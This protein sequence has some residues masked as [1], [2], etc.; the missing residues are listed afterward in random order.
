VPQ[1]EREREEERDRET[2]LIIK[3]SSAAKKNK[4][5]S[6]TCNLLCRF[7]LEKSQDPIS[8]PF[9]TRYQ[10]VNKLFYNHPP[11]FLPALRL[12]DVNIYLINDFSSSISRS[13][14]LGLHI[15]Q[16]KEPLRVFP[17]RITRFWR[18]ISQLSFNYQRHMI[19]QMLK[20][21]AVN[22]W[23]TLLSLSMCNLILI[24]ARS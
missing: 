17:R 7:N 23:R 11:S 4:S 10:I 5:L 1:R 9:L 6:G 19:S 8:K 2:A 12:R 21:N 16:P 13:Y 20:F 22:L 15:T 3:H 14:N 18:D 24:T